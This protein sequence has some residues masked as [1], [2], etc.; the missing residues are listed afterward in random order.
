MPG[1][2]DA[3][4]PVTAF[5]D[6]DDFFDADAQL[7]NYDANLHGLELNLRRHFGNWNGFNIGGIAGARYM[8]LD[9]Q[10]GLTSFAPNGDVGVYR[11]ETENELTRLNIEAK[12]LSRSM[13]STRRYLPLG[14]RS[15]PASRSASFAARWTFS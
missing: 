15:S 3:T 12:S 13:S 4:F 2:S 14:G 9:E 10:F 11:I 1:R 8:A 7:I 5:I 6:I